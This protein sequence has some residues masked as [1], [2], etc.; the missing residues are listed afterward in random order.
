[1]SNDEEETVAQGMSAKEMKV[2]FENREDIEQALKLKKIIDYSLLALIMFDVT[3]LSL[4]VLTF[5]MMKDHAWFDWL[6]PRAR[7]PGGGDDHVHCGHAEYLPQTSSICSY[8]GYSSLPSTS[9]SRRSCG[10]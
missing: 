9:S 5:A 6:G 4:Y 7:V 1:M 10:R 3:V 8:W 2:L